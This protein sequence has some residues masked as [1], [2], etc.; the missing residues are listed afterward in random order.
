MEKTRKEVK[1]D[2]PDNEIESFKNVLIKINK[3]LNLEND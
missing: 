1:K 3:N 2:I